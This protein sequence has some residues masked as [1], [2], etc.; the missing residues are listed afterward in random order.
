MAYDPENHLRSSQ[1]PGMLPITYVYDGDGKKR[2]KNEYGGLTTL[3]WDG[4]DYLQEIYANNASFVSQV[5]PANMTAG[6]QYPITLTFTNTGTRSWTDERNYALGIVPYSQTTVW[7][8]SGVPVTPG[9]IVP[10]GSNFTFVT[11]VTAPST[12]GTYT[13]QWQVGEVY[14]DYFGALSPVASVVV[15]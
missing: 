12:P 11:T 2:I 4:E 9:V 15:S 3:V 8:A 13:M 5:I 14:I 6:V 10:P 1:S 7:T